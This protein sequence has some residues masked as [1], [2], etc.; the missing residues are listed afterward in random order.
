MRSTQDHRLM[1]IFQESQQD[2]QL[3]NLQN[4]VSVQLRD[5]ATQFDKL[6]NH[7]IE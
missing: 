1:H 7:E 2:L 4:N 5:F 6:F 3:R